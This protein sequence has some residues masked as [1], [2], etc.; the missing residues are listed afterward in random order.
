MACFF[1]CLQQKQQQNQPNQQS[2]NDL[3]DDDPFSDLGGLDDIGGDIGVGN[4]LD[5]LF[6]DP[7]PLEM[8]PSIEAHPEL[9]D[10]QGLGQPAP[11]MHVGKGPPADEVIDPQDNE[12]DIKLL[13]QPLAMGFYVS[14]AKTGPL[15]KWFW[16]A[17]P[18]RE[19]H[20]PTCFKVG[21]REG[22]RIVG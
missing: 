18:G 15:P 5:W 3:I 16:S 20:C 11:G 19:D 12:K 8:E 14:T 13:Q 7:Q 21:W 6:P 22:L 9:P 17:C 2:L 4:D 1:C 10:Q